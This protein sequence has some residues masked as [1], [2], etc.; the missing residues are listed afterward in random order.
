MAVNSYG[1]DGHP[2]FLDTDA[3]DI[4]VDP[5]KAAE[6]AGDVGNRIIRANVAAL[7]AYGFKREGLRGYALDSGVEY[8][9]TTA[10][11]WSVLFR[12]LTAFTPTV[13]GLTGVTTVAKFEQRGK[14]VRAQYEVTRSALA[15]PTAP[16]TLSL[17]T[18]IA[19]TSMTRDIGWGS[20]F[21]ANG[22][23]LYSV[24]PRYT[25]GSTV[26]VNFPAASGS[27][28]SQ[29]SNLSA[30]FPT[31]SAHQSGTTLYLCVEYEAA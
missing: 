24:R 14:M 1:P 7:E 10:A 25:G 31:S 5:T 28:I 18:P 30:T 2:I 23:V 16:V 17:P 11:G 19:N 13:V 12:P 26:A 3:P 29:G 9:Y 22:S 4:K 20:F 8:L 21:L 27:A 6:Y 15:S